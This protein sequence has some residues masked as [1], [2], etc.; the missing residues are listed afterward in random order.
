MS[1]VVTTNLRIPRRLH[2]KLRKAA[3]EQQSSLNNEIVARLNSTVG[4]VP[5]RITADLFARLK[6]GD[7]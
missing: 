2:S 1:D 6:R 7:V 5:C 3:K 4:D